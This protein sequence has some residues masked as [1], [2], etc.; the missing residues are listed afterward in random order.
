MYYKNLEIY[1]E[2][3][4]LVTDIYKV[5]EDFPQ[6]EQ[7]GMVSQMRRCAVSIPS[8]IAEGCG[9]YSDKE[10]VKFLSIA[11]GSIEELDTQLE[12]ALRLNFI[13][14]ISSLSEKLQ[15]VK[16]LIGGLKKHLTQSP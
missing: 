6:N 14:D 12:I 5:T 16:A 11:A 10:T 15:K 3:I 2:A 7:Y 9:R 4:E 1:R 8:N 13:D